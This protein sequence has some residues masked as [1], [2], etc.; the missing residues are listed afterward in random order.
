[1]SAPFVW[2]LFPGAVALILLLLNR[3]PRLVQILGVAAGILLA[4]L[5][6]QLTVPQLLE[7]GPLSLK[8]GDSATVLGRSF[9][10][11]DSTRALLGL[12][13]LNAAL[14]F[15]LAGAAVLRRPFVPLGLG[16][17]ALLTASLAVRPFLFAALFIQVVA[18]IS[19]PLL[20]PPGQEAGRGVLRF[21]TFQLLGGPFILFTGWMLTGIEASPGALTPVIRAS[22][23]LGFG[24]LLLLGIAPFHT[25]MP[26]IAQDAHPYVS[27][28]LFVTLPGMVAIFG[29]G[30]LERFVWLRES[31]G[32]LMLFLVVS[33]VMV[34]IGGLG[35]AFQEHLGRMLGF[36]VVY[37]LGVSV[38]AAASGGLT[39][40]RL[41][42][43]LMIVRGLAILLWSL[44]LVALRQI[45]GDLTLTALRGVGRRYPWAAA[46]AF[47][48][49]LTI[50]GFPLL[51]GFS[52]RLDL[53]RALAGLSNSLALML[54]LGS[55]GLIIAAVRV[56]TALWSDGNVPTD[57]SPEAGSPAVAL[58]L[59]LFALLI[60]GLL[61]NALDSY[62]N[63]L[64]AAFP[65]LAR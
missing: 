40:L 39:G 53:L 52:N 14:W 35:S 49:P 10:L 8:L 27:G 16:M 60:L 54:I 19:V 9:V 59:L 32:L 26:M 37:E 31:N 36:A 13:Y 11:G 2:I 4:I 48:A 23:L 63:Q 5:A 18:L 55:T 61:P 46:G 34:L 38:A 12:L 17:S 24:F 20:A 41:F 3:W 33:A 45:A 62:V 64:A 44:V 28:Y 15:L 29:L 56:A 51:A 47:I 43:S 57:E 6:W 21:L 1:M 42:F 58:A 25:W 65:N 22:V 7:V 50:A 30:F